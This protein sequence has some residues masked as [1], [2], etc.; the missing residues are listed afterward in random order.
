M[1]V[2]TKYRNKRAYT[3]LYRAAAGDD[4][5]KCEE[6]L[7]EGANPNI[8]V[9]G[10]WTPLC[11]AAHDGHLPVVSLLIQHGAVLD[12][13][14]TDGYT[15]LFRAEEN[16]HYDVCSLEMHIDLRNDDVQSIWNRFEKI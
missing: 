6:L 13:V 3:A 2:C 15:P 16:N 11:V 1:I 5:N 4:Y 14:D 9:H 7:D 10:G 8:G 12:T